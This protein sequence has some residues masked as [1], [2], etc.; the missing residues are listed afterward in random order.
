MPAGIEGSNECINY[1][2]AIPERARRNPLIE[3]GSCVVQQ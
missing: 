1:H 2:R 3:E